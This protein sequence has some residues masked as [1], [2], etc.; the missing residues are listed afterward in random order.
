MNTPKVNEDEM[1]YRQIGPGGDP[2]YF[3]PDRN[4]PIHQSR[5]IPTSADT[6]GLSLIRSRFRTEVWSAYRLEQPSVRFRLA[7]IQAELLRR[8]ALDSEFESL[9]Y[10]VSAD[11]IDDRFGEPWAHCVVAEMNRAN[12]DS[13]VET[14]KKIKEWALRATKLIKKEDVIGPFDAPTDDDPYRP[15]N[16]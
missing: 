7:V 11:G 1:L 4:P 3:N 9:S 16:E 5:F 8:I 13:D 10:R 2:I 14:K 15:K 12:Y 6:D